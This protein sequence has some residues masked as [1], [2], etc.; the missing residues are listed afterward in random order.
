RRTSER[1]L[2]CCFYCTALHAAGNPANC[3][4]LTQDFFRFDRIRRRM[5]RTPVLAALLVLLVLPRHSPA[6]T[7]PPSPGALADDPRLARKAL[8]H[9]EGLPVG[10]LLS[11][12]RQ[13]S[14][15][16]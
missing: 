6:G 5:M 16:A 8:L 13:K 15:V 7:Q 9:V 4:S 3:A 12:L 2:S 10:E 11:Q 1:L 14:G